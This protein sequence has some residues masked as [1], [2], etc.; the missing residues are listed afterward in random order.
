MTAR[1]W[2]SASC[3]LLLASAPALAGVDLGKIDRTIKKEP[4]Y[5][6]KTPGYCLLVFGPEARTRVWLV[7]DGDTLYIDR[8]GSGDL[9]GKDKHVAKGKGLL[10]TFPGGQIRDADGK[11]K[12][13]VTVMQFKEKKET[14]HFVT[15]TV[16]GKDTY[17]AGADAEGTL[18]FAARPQDAPVIHFG[19]PLH[20][21]LNSKFADAEKAGLARGTQP[22][23]LYAWVGTPGLGKGT[24]AALLHQRVPN[25]VHP[26]AE[27][28]FP[29]KQATGPALKARIVL[30]ERC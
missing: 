22:T 25:S 14:F 5:Q 3:W 12:H 28:E 29:N 20:M 30:K 10:A 21:G 27:I 7:L 11:T 6:T 24:F 18:A 9:T 17:M 13:T 4:V 1:T 15:A 23:E 2:L 16:A 8:D 19:G 26:V